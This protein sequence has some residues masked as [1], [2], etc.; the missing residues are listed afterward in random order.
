MG[1]SGLGWQ[2]GPLVFELIRGKDCLLRD[3]VILSR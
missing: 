2:Y 1:L 3:Q